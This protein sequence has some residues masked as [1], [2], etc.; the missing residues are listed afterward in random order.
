M[1][2]YPKLVE[3][4]ARLHLSEGLTIFHNKKLVTNSIIL[5]VV[6]FI[7]FASF[8]GIVLYMNRK[9]KLSAYDQKLKDIKDQEYILTKIRHYQVN[10]K[11]INSPI[12]NLPNVYSPIQVI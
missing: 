4:N 10:K 9:K 12:T 5:N 2:Y 11:Q 8:F 3:Y 7:L 1:E 6:V